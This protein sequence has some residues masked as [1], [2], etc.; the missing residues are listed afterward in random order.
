MASPQEPPLV[1]TTI[2]YV[3]HVIGL[4]RNKFDYYVQLSQ[5]NGLPI[6][7]LN[8]PGQKMYI[9]TKP[10]LIQAAQK[11]PRVLAFPPIEAMFASK[12]LRHGSIGTSIRQVMEDTVLDGQWLLK[13]D[14]IVQMPSRII[15]KDSSL[16]GSDVD[17]FNPRRFMKALKVTKSGSGANKR[18]G[19]AAFRAFGGG[20]TLCPGRHFAMNEVFAVTAM[21]VLRYDM[22]PTA[23]TWSMPSI[24]NSSMAGFL[25]EPDTDIEVEI[26]LRRGFEE[27]RF[28]CGLEDSDVV[29]AVTA[30]DHP[31]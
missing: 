15:H 26:S 14:S 27:E 23:G 20:T 9:I 21:F 25:M 8:L 30:E 16:W 3:G 28:A 5:N 31:I 11:Q 19:A 13:K 17:E 12:T 4:M 7:T 1:T 24:A 6:F 29:L 22:V 18:H 10:D 2:P